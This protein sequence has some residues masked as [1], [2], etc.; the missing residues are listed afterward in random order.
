MRAQID[1]PVTVAKAILVAEI[2]DWKAKAGT[3]W[4]LSARRARD[5]AGSCVQ[6]QVYESM[7]EE[8][9]KKW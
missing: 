2:Y 7:S 4:Q 5:A 8:L 9:L 1:S 6:M 3:E